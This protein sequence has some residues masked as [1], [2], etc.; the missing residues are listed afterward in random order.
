[1]ACRL[2]GAKPL[3]EP[4]WIIINWTLRN[5]LQWNFNRNSYIF[6]QENVFENV[7]CKM[8]SISS[9]PQ[10]VKR[11]PHC[12]LWSW[13]H[14]VPCHWGIFNLIGIC[15][16]IVILFHQHPNCTIHTYYLKLLCTF[17]NCSFLKLNW[18][19]VQ[20]FNWCKIVFWISITLKFW[21]TNSHINEVGTHDE[22]AYQGIIY[23]EISYANNWKWWHLIYP[24]HRILAP[25]PVLVS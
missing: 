25:A 15:N 24:W 12:I 23:F 21:M 8:P 3:S 10:C 14:I 19:N 18:T 11:K 1:M 5:K 4:C 9:R 13:S 6:I 2:E 7:V 17:D 22:V 20:K 16:L